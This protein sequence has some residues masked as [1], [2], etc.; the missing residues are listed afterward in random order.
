[1]KYLLDTNACI[2]W[3]RMS[4][5]AIVSRMKK[6]SPSDLAIC[7]VVVAELIFGA[8][9]SAPA[10]QAKNRLRVSR[11]RAQFTSLAFDDFAAQYYGVIRSL[12]TAAGNLIGPNDLLIA[13]I[14]L[15]NRLIL[16]THNVSKFTRVPGLQIEDWQT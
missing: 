10:H 5:P 7:S 13:S 8:E 16:V 1:M 4:Q 9:R 2:G 12:L 3:L 14:A 11:L 15:A 6:E